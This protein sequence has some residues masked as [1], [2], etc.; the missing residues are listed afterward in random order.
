MSAIEIQDLQ[1]SYDGNKALNG[2]DLNIEEGEIYGFL[3]PN[4]AG[5]TTAIKIILGLIKPDEGEIS[6]L[7]KD[8]LE[9]SMSVRS[10]IGYLPEKLEM[11]GDLTVMENLRFLCELKGCPDEDI[12]NLLKGFEMDDWG[13]KKIRSLSKGMLQRIGFL[14]TMI[15]DPDVYILDEPTS[16]LDPRVRRWVKDK[17]IELKEEGKTIF[18]SSHVLSEVQEL[19]DRVGFIR[20]GEIIGEGDVDTFFDDLNMFPKLELKLDNPVKAFKM[21]EGVDFIERPRLVDDQLTLY[22]EE[23]RKMDV[24][25]LLLDEG[26][27][28]DDFSV[29]NPD[30]EEVFVRLTEG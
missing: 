3:G 24:I 25:K 13:D 23:K 5:K 29:K 8:A 6:V 20:E 12:G 7:G 17:I 22:C 28:I 19:C 21:I 4:G 1:K 11:Y 27:E 18:L 9:D 15:G 30:L 14:Q 26:F 2:L 16:G 10:S